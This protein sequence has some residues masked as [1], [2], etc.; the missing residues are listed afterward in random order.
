[1]AGRAGV[2]NTLATEKLEVL[3]GSRGNPREWALRRGELVDVQKIIADVRKAIDD[4]KKS[5]QQ[6]KS[7]IDAI[8]V[9]IGLIESRL[10]EAE[11]AIND[12]ETALNALEVRIDLAEDALTQIET[13]VA[14]INNQ[15]A[16]I[17]IEL[18]SIGGDVTAL[19]NSINVL[20][21][22]VTTMQADITGILSDITELQLDVAELE[23]G[24][25]SLP[26]VA[27][28]NTALRNHN[29]QWSSSSSGTPIAGSFG[30]GTTIASS[31]ND[32]TQIGIINATGQ[33]FVR[34]R[35]NGTWSA[36]QD[37]VAARAEPYAVQSNPGATPFPANA[38][39]A[40]PFFTNIEISGGITV[41]SSKTFTVPV[42][43]LYQF[44]LEVRA[45]GGLTGM[46]VIGAP[47]GLSIDGVTVPTSLRPGY[48]AAYQVQTTTI[49]R[50]V[51]TERLA[52]GAQRVAYL[53]NQGMASYQVAS[54]MIKITR[55]SA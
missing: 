31:A 52:A 35:T 15:L 38:Y 50:L 1:M 55:L 21:N 45:N 5:L 20:Q 47:L 27:D 13:S 40:I 9:Q 14:A 42:A 26:V 36:W 22:K 7:D 4:L 29:F 32:L 24:D 2:N 41:S 8:N 17:N 10:A 28:L 51:C 37:V 49:M 33:I 39:T 16:H 23:A 54:A 11:Q 6:V 30:R 12:M 48:S 18:G 19:Q 3:W 43:G 25:A 34:Y 44:E 46:P 53:L